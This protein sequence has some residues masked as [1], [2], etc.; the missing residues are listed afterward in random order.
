MT[1]PIPSLGTCDLDVLLSLALFY[2]RSIIEPIRNFGFRSTD[3]FH[4]SW[5]SQLD[6]E[7]KTLTCESTLKSDLVYKLKYDHLVIGVGS[8]SSTLGV[9]GVLQHA[10]FLKVS[11][12]TYAYKL[13]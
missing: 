1:D 9:P 8:L 4:L 7:S 2:Y 3:H 6:I 13:H 10:S 12:A 5:A 11:S